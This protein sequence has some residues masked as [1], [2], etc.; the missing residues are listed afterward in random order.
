VT[1]LRHPDVRARFAQLGYEIVG[2]T[3]EQYAAAMRAE[4]EAFGR[5][6]RSTGIR[7]E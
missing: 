1:A 4:S 3:P 7:A 5:V 6:I 2:D